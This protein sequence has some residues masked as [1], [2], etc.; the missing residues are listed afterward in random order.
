M[1][2][3]CSSGRG[4]TCTVNSFEMHVL[5]MSD[6]AFSASISPYIEVGKVSNVIPLLT[7]APYIVLVQYAHSPGPILKARNL[8]ASVFRRARS[9]FVAEAVGSVAEPWNSQPLCIST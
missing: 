3:S 5:F 4:L 8:R 6:L 2:T 1:S 7:Y 9:C